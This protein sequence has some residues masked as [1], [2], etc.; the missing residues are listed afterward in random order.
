MHPVSFSYIFLCLVT[1]HHKRIAKWRIFIK[2]L[3]I[4]ESI[5]MFFK[6]FNLKL[7]NVT[8]RSQRKSLYADHQL[9]AIFSEIT[10]VPIRWSL[11]AKEIYKSKHYL[12]Y[13]TLLKI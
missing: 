7:Y 1:V 11:S 13:K 6:T 9:L 8:Y 4:Y 2:E 10:V 12:K 3:R 5:L